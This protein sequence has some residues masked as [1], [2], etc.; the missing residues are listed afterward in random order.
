[1]EQTGGDAPPSVAY[2]ATVLLLNY[3]CVGAGDSS[4]NCVYRLQGDH[5]PAEL[6]LLGLGGDLRLALRPHAVTAREAA[7]Q[8]SPR[9]STFVL[10]C[11]KLRIRAPSAYIRP[12]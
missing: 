12:P 10:H 1:M 2:R 8:H 5:S 3:V 11:L 4:R 6:H 9:G 7:L